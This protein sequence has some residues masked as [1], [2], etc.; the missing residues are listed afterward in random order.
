MHEAALFPELDHIGN[1]VRK[2]VEK[3]VYQ[4]RIGEVS[5]LLGR[6]RTS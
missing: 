2:V 5:E 6:T 4:L 3:N 1:Y